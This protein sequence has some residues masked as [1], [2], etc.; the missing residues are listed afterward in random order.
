[1]R[2]RRDSRELLSGIQ[3]LRAASRKRILFM[4]GPEERSWE[5]ELEVTSY[6]YYFLYNKFK[7]A[8]SK[9]G[10]SEW[11]LFWGTY[12]GVPSTRSLAGML[13]SR[14]GSG[15]V[16]VI[17]KITQSQQRAW[18]V[19][20]GTRHCAEIL[21]SLIREFTPFPWGGGHYISSAFSKKQ[22]LQGLSSVTHTQKH[23]MDGLPAWASPILE[24]AMCKYK[25]E[26]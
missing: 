16:T 22:G 14:S 13:Q 21:H 5:Q 23:P 10:S 25:A 26:F 19:L 3:H 6:C 17:V 18:Q 8:L 7:T 20:S 15:R 24:Q 1:M 4:A 12:R 11:V 2:T 9:V